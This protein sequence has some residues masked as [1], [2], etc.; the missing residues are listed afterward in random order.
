MPRDWIANSYVLSVSI[1]IAELVRQNHED[2]ADDGLGDDIGGS[3]HMSR[4]AVSKPSLNALALFLLD[5]LQ[6]P[7][8]H[9]ASG[10]SMRC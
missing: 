8:T 5:E 6:Q 7:F 4:A 1:L 3:E 10:A 2:G 9:V